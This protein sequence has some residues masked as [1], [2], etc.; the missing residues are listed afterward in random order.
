MPIESALPTSRPQPSDSDAVGSVR[1]AESTGATSA[2]AWVP[3]WL[4]LAFAA[5]LAVHVAAGLTTAITIELMRNL[6]PFAVRVRAFD[7]ALLPY[8]RAVSYPATIWFLLAY[9]WPLVLYFRC[10]ATRPADLVV[11]RRAVS[12][13]TVL[14][15]GGMAPWLVSTVLFPL[16]TYFQFGRWSTDLMSQQVLSP[17]VNGFLAA[18]TSY[19]LVDWV[20]RS[21]VIPFVFPDG[22][23]IAEVP[24]A[25][26]VRV[27]TRMLVFLTAVAFIPLFSMLG[28]A[29]TA[30]VRLDEGL[31]VTT[32]VHGL[33]AGST[34]VFFVYTALG[35]VLTLVLARTFT[36]PLSEV[37]QALRRVQ[38][39][40][41]AVKVRVESADEIGSLQAG[42]NETVAG[43]REKERILAAF[44][45]VVEPSVRDRL[46]AG[47]LDAGGEM[48][49]ASVMFC[50]LRGFTSLAERAAPDE[51]VSTLNEFFTTVTRWV[52]ECDGFVDKFIGD[53]LLVVFGLFDETDTGEKGA[54][55]ALRC[56]L[57]IPDRL[58]ALNQRRA[59]A[60]RSPL[61]VT[62]GVH[63]GP[64][65]AGTIGAQDRHEYTV[66][67]DTV[68]VA[69]R[70]Q[71]LS[72]ERGGGLAVSAGTYDLAATPTLRARALERESVT[73]R[74]RERPVEF[75]LL[76][77]DDSSASGR[78]VGG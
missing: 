9:V 48:R 78:D 32:I 36:L 19:L 30:Q 2:A 31:D 46:L 59:A 44:G 70:L 15:I 71:Q 75:V 34:G 63:T 76:S 77:L 64:V 28:L 4:L 55:A 24:G 8:W 74:G 45:R 38:A 73:L 23:S 11:Q 62:M 57:G 65:L 67:G 52:R 1:A 37:A 72:K 69:A 53:A 27:R 49:I 20:F 25:W 56:A 54:A 61:R 40:D 14:A 50:D 6:S 7:L 12:F 41:L 3:A 21:R 42:V 51:V 47:A 68:N 60:G 5:A 35:V 33:A 22:S 17:L 43:L 13:P 66:I 58:A 16:L 26:A 10:G 39:G 29:R 18:T